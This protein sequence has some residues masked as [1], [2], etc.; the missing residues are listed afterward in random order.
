MS[1]ET[2]ILSKA[3]GVVAK[4]LYDAADLPAEDREKWVNRPSR[5]E[6][7]AKYRAHHQI[8]EH[9]PDDLVMQAISES[10]DLE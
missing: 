1:I 6:R 2:E 9:I 4:A 7:I 8:P 3:S 5:T 10:W